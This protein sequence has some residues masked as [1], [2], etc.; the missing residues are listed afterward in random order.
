MKKYLNDGSASAGVLWDAKALGCLTAW[1]G[2]QLAQGQQF[3]PTQKVDAC[4]L[5]AVT[6]DSSTKILLMGKPLTYTK[7]N[8]GDYNF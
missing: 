5:D 8:V 3:Q 6:Y 1:A 7:E 2:Q 4:S